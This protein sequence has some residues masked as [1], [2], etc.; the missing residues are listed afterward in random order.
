M[1][2]KKISYTLFLGISV[3][4]LFVLALVY[5]SVST[6]DRGKSLQPSLVSEDKTGVSGEQE[7]GVPV[8]E[9]E[10]KEFRSPE[11]YFIY[12][13]QNWDSDF[14]ELRHASALYTFNYP[15]SWTFNGS[16]MFDDEFGYRAATFLDGLTQLGSGQKCFDKVTYNILPGAN[17]MEQPLEFISKEDLQD[18]EGV[19]LVEKGIFSGGFRGGSDWDRELYVK[20]YCIVTGEYAFVIRFLDTDIETAY[21]AWFDRVARSFQL[22]LVKP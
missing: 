17:P 2:F 13:T 15:P 9:L 4:L 14:A 22:H 3:I 5:R 18:I 20:S 11:S 8:A 21:D 6:Q 19:K 7:T 16:G 1:E 12:A 10:W